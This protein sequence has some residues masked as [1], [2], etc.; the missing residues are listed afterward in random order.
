MHVR[1]RYLGQLLE[2]EE[3]VAALRQGIAVLQTAIDAQARS[4]AAAFRR[5]PC[6]TVDA[7]AGSCCM[8]TFAGQLADRPVWLLRM[9][10][11]QR[12]IGAQCGM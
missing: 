9:R 2:A 4:E 3:A 10:D 11:A 1:R 5:T 8:H 7:H 6:T 12:K